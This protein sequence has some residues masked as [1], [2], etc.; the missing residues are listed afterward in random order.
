MA[1]TLKSGEFAIATRVRGRTCHRGDVIAFRTPQPR[2]FCSPELRVK[3]V[4][5][6]AGDPV[7]PSMRS[8]R[9]IHETVVPERSVAVAGDGINSEDSR[10]LGFIRTEDVVGVLWRR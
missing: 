6:C 5:A 2:A 9:I 3:R 7:P 8:S 4:V 1:P 10:Q